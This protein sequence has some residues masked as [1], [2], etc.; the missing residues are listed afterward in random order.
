ML[1][2]NS[3]FHEIITYN[4]NTVGRIQQNTQAP[5]GVANYVPC[6]VTKSLPLIRDKFLS[7]LILL[8]SLHN[9]C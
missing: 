5:R 2:L 7:P 3:S 8:L 9:N 4:G 1:K 6:N